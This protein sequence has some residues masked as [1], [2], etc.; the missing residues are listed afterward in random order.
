[1][2]SDRNS[3]AAA[4][5]AVGP[6]KVSRLPKV[7]E[8]TT[9]NGIAVHAVRRPTVPLVEVRLRIPIA[10]GRGGGDGV[11]ERVLAESLLSGTATRSAVDI[12]SEL[13]RLGATMGV[14]VG[15]EQ[16]MLAGSVLAP[17]LTAYLELLGDVLAAAAFPK[18]EVEVQRGR[19]AQ[20]LSIAHTQPGSIAAQA[21]AGRLYP[22]HPYG[23]PLPDP[24]AAAAVTPAVLRRFHADR[25]R[26]GGAELVVVGDVRPARLFTAADKALAAWESG[27]KAVVTVP[28]PPPPVPGAILIV[29]RP[30]SVQTSI[31]MAGTATTRHDPQHPAVLV[32]ET[33]LGGY[34][35]SRLNHNLREDKGYTYGAHSGVEHR[36]QGSHVVISAD[37]A[38]GVTAPALAEMHYELARMATGTLTADELRSAQ[39]YRNGQMALGT[40]SQVGFASFLSTLLPFGLGVSYLRDLPAAIERVTVDEAA[41]AARRYLAPNRLVTVL[42]GDAAVIAPQVEALAPVEVRSSS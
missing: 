5:P 21:V 28:T 22:D 19:V 24:A 20:E 6:L 37:V 1:M 25:V 7:V 17:N 26:P 30:G 3:G 13:Q 14:N 10:Q 12:A 29:D 16:F 32:A 23:R 11:R 41:E 31:R 15:L 27:G 9:P 18:P 34:F 39:R 2:K 8:H 36:L 38:T 35:S 40:Q 4:I 42:V 33:A